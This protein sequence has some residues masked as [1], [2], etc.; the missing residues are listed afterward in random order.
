MFERNILIVIFSCQ[1]V[2]L[3]ECK[4]FLHKILKSNFFN[5]DL[6]FIIDENKYFKASSQGQAIALLHNYELNQFSKLKRSHIDCLS[7]LVQ[8]MTIDKESD[9]VAIVLFSNKNNY[10]KDSI[11][12]KQSLTTKRLGLKIHH[13]VLD[14]NQTFDDINQIF[15]GN[16]NGYR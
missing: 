9:N 2:E 14:N 12:V 5:D 6:F 7:S 11:L 1:F 10:D 13:Q 16:D 4:D 8:E 3:V 15:N